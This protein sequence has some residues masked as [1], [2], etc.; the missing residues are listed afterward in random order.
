MHDLIASPFLD[1]H[2]V[3][4]PDSPK[5]LTIP[6]AHYRQLL[7][8]DPGQ[9]APTWPADA[10]RDAWGLDLSGRP[11]RNS[12]LVRTPSAHGFARASYELNLGCNY[13]CSHC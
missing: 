4:R 10:A 3:V 12:V 7:D 9:T 5:R 1:R 2:L 8:A 13:D 11:V 6:P